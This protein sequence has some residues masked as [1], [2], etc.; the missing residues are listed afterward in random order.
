MVGVATSAGRSFAVVAVAVVVAPLVA[1]T[2][3]SP[4]DAYAVEAT[5][6]KTGVTYDLSALTG[7]VGYAGGVAYAYRSCYDP[8][9]IMLLSEQEVFGSRCLAVRVQIPPAVS[10]RALRRCVLPTAPQCYWGE[11]RRDVAVEVEPG[12][13]NE[14]L[15]LGVIRLAATSF[16]KFRPELVPIGRVEAL[17]VSGELVLEPLSG[18]SELQVRRESLPRSAYR[19]PMSCLLSLSEPCLGLMTLIPGC[20]APLRIEEGDYRV[21][22]TLYWSASAQA[23]LLFRGLEITCEWWIHV[24]PLKRAG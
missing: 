17:T 5:L 11:L 14:T 20:D 10:A 24:E 6:S 21:W 7:A 16:V 12:S 18:D 2:R 3:L 4:F 1:S 9:L 15:E 22:L 19:I 13:G 8:R 23:V